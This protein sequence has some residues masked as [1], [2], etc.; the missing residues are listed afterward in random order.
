MK[1]YPHMSSEESACYTFL[2][3]QHD[4]ARSL[5]IER[6]AGGEWS[7]ADIVRMLA[8]LSERHGGLPCEMTPEFLEDLRLKVRP[9]D[10]MD[11][12]PEQLAISS[13]IVEQDEIAELLGLE[14]DAD[15]EWSDADIVHILAELNRRW[16]EWPPNLRS[17]EFLAKLRWQA[18]VTARLDREEMDRG[19]AAGRSC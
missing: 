1:T 7:D 2:R 16:G 19:A 18:R 14:R 11:T 3:E 17:P 8:E 13:F 12:S 10:V 9:V 15:G 6:N 4:I 5:G